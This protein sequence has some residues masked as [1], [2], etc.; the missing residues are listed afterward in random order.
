M[1]YQFTINGNAALFLVCIVCVAGIVAGMA[2]AF[3]IGRLLGEC[4]ALHDA[5]RDREDAINDR[6][7]A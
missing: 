7:N 2:I 4:E 3:K 6:E 5:I 1:E